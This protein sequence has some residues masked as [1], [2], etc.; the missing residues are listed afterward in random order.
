MKQVFYCNKNILSDNS[1][2]YEIF[3]E[4][5]DQRLGSAATE[6]QAD[7]LVVA[8]NDAVDDWVTTTIHNSIDCV[9]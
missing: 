6:A 3:Q 1:V 2:I 4:G 7:A 8:L 9:G 5:S